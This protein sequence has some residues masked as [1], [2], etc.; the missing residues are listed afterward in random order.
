LGGAALI[1]LIVALIYW[2]RY[3]FV[4]SQYSKALLQLNGGATKGTKGEGRPAQAEI[5]L[6]DNL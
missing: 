5:R 4:E 3:R 2:H 6:E 1:A